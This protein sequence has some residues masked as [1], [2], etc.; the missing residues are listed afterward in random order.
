MQIANILSRNFMKIIILLFVLQ[1]IT[2]WS[3]NVYTQKKSKHVVNLNDEI[4]KDLF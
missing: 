4:L 2:F 1:I 3:I